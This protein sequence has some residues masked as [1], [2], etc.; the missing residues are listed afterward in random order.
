MRRCKAKT[1]AGKRCKAN[2]QKDR[3]V[4]IAHDEERRGSVGFGGAQP[5]SGR[6]RKPKVIEVLRERIEENIDFWLQPLVDG[7]TADAAKVVGDGEH[8][9][10]EFH[11][12]HPTRIK[13]QREAL[14]RAFGKAAQSVDVKHSAEESQLDTE[15]RELLAKLGQFPEQSA[16]GHH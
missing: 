14:D 3:E 4:C 16:N 11:A 13:A 9:R 6:P 2:S 1:K 7:I 10:L 12:D 5:G 15:I 8:A